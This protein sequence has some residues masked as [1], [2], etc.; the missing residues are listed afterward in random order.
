MLISGCVY[1]EPYEKYNKVSNNL[2]SSN[3]IREQYFLSIRKRIYYF[4]FKN[5]NVIA[6]GVVY[7]H[8]SILKNGTLENLEVDKDK[9]EAKAELISRA[10]KAVR[11]AAPFPAF[12]E[13]LNQYPKLTFDVE[14]EFNITK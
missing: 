4:A 12:P 11:E 9:T 10:L 8:F 6:T 14:L 5:Y 3:S 1:Y 7:L 13:D 2:D